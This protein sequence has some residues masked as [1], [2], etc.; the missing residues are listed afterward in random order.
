VSEDLPESV[1]H[2]R[3]RVGGHWGKTV[4]AIGGYSTFIRHDEDILI[5]VMFSR[6]VASHICVLH[7]ADLERNPDELSRVLPEE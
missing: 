7:N 2:R 3:W 5:G 6:K 4:I 1:L